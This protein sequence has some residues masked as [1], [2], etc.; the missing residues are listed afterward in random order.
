MYCND[1]Q[2]EERETKNFKDLL[3]EHRQLAIDA[4]QRIAHY[5]T[6]LDLEI[7]V[8]PGTIDYPIQG[9]TSVISPRLFDGK[10]TILKTY[11]DAKDDCVYFCIRADIQG[12]L[13]PP[14]QNE[15]CYFIK[16]PKKR[17]LFV[18][19]RIVSIEQTDSYIRER[20][21][22]FLNSLLGE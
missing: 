15:T 22:P 12:H 6:I 4:I 20:I 17:A 19:H 8:P 3:P 9:S 2:R 11:Y 7:I 14:N 21:L 18:C 13:L 5:T 16:N 10:E 1:H